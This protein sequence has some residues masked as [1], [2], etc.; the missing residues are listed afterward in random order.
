[1]KFGFILGPDYSGTTEIALELART[2]DFQVP[3]PRG[4][5]F[6]SLK[7]PGIIIPSGLYK[8]HTTIAP[9]SYM[10]LFRKLKKEPAIDAS[11]SYFYWPWAVQLIERYIHKAKYVL[12][13][14]EPI[15]RL[16]HQYLDGPKR[17]PPIKDILEQEVR[18]RRNAIYPWH[19]VHNRLHQC[20][21]D[22]FIEHILTIVNDSDR[23]L[24]VKW[25]DYVQNTVVEMARI[26]YF[27]GGPELMFPERHD[28]R[29]YQPLDS[30]FDD[31]SRK[32]IWRF[33]A[34]RY[35]AIEKLTGLNLESWLRA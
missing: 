3:R 35:S 5:D 2:G 32:L 27:L 21:Y 7:C 9:A 15:A 25:E 30:V 6:F 24:F 17:Q 33:A 31:H 1:M 14:R 28:E 26:Q 29:Y 16:T 8:K 11:E 19:D 20:Q 13:I 22:T 12:V 10:K 34:P 18:W 23:V 4:L